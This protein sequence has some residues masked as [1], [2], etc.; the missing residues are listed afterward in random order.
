MATKKQKPKMFN[1]PSGNMPEPTKGQLGIG[2]ALRAAEKGPNPHLP[3]P[4]ALIPSVR[5]NRMIGCFPEAGTPGV[6]YVG[7]AFRGTTIFQPTKA[8]GGG[9]SGKNLNKD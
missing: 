1:D 9:A 4:N 7:P 2:P 6:P 5:P 3:I 8:A